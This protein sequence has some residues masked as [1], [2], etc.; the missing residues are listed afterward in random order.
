MPVTACISK[1]A[2]TSFGPIRPRIAV[3]Q[4][5]VARQRT[6]YL[7]FTGNE[8]LR[9]HVLTVDNPTR[10]YPVIKWG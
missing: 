5:G 7:T 9:F 6:A 2:D 3:F 10:W 1:V 4:V 8:G